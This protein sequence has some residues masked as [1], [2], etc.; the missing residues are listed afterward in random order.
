MAKP[1]Y[2]EVQNNEAI[3]SPIKDVRFRIESTHVFA[4]VRQRLIECFGEMIFMCHA[5][6]HFQDCD[7]WLVTISSCVRRRT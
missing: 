5:P 7:H 2:D 4:D 1:G 6:F 3:N